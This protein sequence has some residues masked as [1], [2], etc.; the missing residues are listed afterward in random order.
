M[1]LAAKR[2]PKL[3]FVWVGDGAQR[4]EYEQRLEDL[5]IR[6]HRPPH[7]AQAAAGSGAG[8][9]RRDGPAGF[10]P[11]NGRVCLRA[12]VQALLMECPVISLDID[13]GR[14]SSFL[15]GPVH[16][17]SSTMSPLWPRS[18]VALAGDAERRRLGQ[19]GRQLCLER[20]DH[21]KM[22]ADLESLYLSLRK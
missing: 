19:A 14:R 18:A 12:A 1:A 15:G 17:F 13:G 5:G 10:M 3:R 22:T 16:W 8:D 20:F 6:S 2:N 21:R 4:A 11:P 7:R 9:A